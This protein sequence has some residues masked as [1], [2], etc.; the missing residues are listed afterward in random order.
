MV[1]ENLG[2]LSLG[3]AEVGRSD[4]YVLAGVTDFFVLRVLL[5]NVI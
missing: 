5:A 4:L 3:G 1:F 2:P